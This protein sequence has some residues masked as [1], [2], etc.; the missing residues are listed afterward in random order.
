MT[1]NRAEKARPEFTHANRRIGM[2]AGKC[3]GFGR[4][5]SPFA[6]SLPF[7]MVCAI[8]VVVPKIIFMADV[9]VPHAGSN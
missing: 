5:S 7:P 3:F 6:R 4:L 2:S 9:L 1:A 8:A